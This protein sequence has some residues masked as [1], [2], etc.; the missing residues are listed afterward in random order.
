[1]DGTTTE[2]E[3]CEQVQTEN[4]YILEIGLRFKAK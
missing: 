1:M 2:N 4:N 3:I